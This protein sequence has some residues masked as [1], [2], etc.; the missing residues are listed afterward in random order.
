VICMPELE[1]VG[2]VV[3]LKGATISN[4]T[5]SKIKKWV[6]CKNVSQVCGFL[7][8]VGIRCGRA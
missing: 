2:S 8:T 3:L 6:A 7:R 4:T 1:L 5:L